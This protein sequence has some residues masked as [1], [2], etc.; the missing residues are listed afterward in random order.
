MIT[1]NK[2]DTVIRRSG[3]SVF[4][5][6]RWKKKASSVRNEWPPQKHAKRMPVKILRNQRSKRVFMMDGVESKRLNNREIGRAKKVLGERC[7]PEHLKCIA[8]MAAHIKQ[9]VIVSVECFIHS[10]S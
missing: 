2:V 1:T 5:E 7:E 3:E 6:N 10:F 8:N 9:P 4:V